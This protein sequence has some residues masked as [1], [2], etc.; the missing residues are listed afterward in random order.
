MPPPDVCTPHIWSV[1]GESCFAKKFDELMEIFKS[2]L[3]KKAVP[4]LFYV[5]QNPISFK[6]SLQ[7]LLQ[8]SLNQPSFIYGFWNECEGILG[9]TPER[10]FRLESN[11]SFRTAAVAGT[12]STDQ[13]K[14]LLR[15]KKLKNEH[16]LVI[17]GIQE[18]L[19]SFGRVSIGQTELLSLSH[20][21][22]LH[23]PIEAK[24]DKSV[25]L[26]NLIKALHPTPALGAFPKD[27]G[28]KWLRNLNQLLPRGRYGAPAGIKERDFF[29]SYVAIR[30]VQWNAQGSKIGVGCG[31]LNTSD[32]KKER[33]ELSL[34]YKAI[35]S[36][37][38]LT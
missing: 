14:V 11:G 15:D 30:N 23:T 28:F 1:Q 2:G 33:E 9:S 34:K 8:H 26:E 17:Q 6:N 29:T 25:N 12:V 22:H 10:F 37:L 24:I 32:F 19:S 36:M 20:L 16:D 5:S 35:C 27:R 4:Y 31:V 21:S 18:T 3:L 7:N 38:N 13:E